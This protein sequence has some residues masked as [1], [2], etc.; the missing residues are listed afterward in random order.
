M[1]EVDWYTEMQ[2]IGKNNKQNENYNGDFFLI[3]KK[4]EKKGL[5]K[6]VTSTN[7]RQSIDVSK[8]LML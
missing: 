8:I 6:N 4:F 1:V 2:L 5:H 3:R 7:I